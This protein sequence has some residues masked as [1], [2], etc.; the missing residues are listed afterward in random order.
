MHAVVIDVTISDRTAAEAE[1]DGLAAQ[2]SAAPGFVA[3]YWV[4]LAG[5]KG[6]SMLVFD[7][8][9]AAE[10]LAAMARTAPA[11]AVTTER[12]EVGEVIRHA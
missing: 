2:V 3:A 6:T 7:N 9:A 12:I 4:H 10:G 8:P 1:L 11:A 5:D